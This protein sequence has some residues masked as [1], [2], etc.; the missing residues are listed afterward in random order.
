MGC[1]C[2]CEEFKLVYKLEKSQNQLENLPSFLQ[3]NWRKWRSLRALKNCEDRR[4]AAEGCGAANKVSFWWRYRGGWK[5][6]DLLLES[7]KDIPRTQLRPLHQQL[8]LEADWWCCCTWSTADVS[9]LWT[10]KM[11]YSLSLGVNAFLWQFRSGGNPKITFQELMGFGFFKGAFPAS[12]TLPP[13][14]LTSWQSTWKILVSRAL[15]CCQA[16]FDTKPRAWWCVP[17]WMISSVV[18][19][20]RTCLVGWRDREK[21]HYF[22]RGCCSQSTPRSSRTSAFLEEALLL[23]NQW[24]ADRSTWEVCWWVGEA[25]RPWCI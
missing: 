25:L 18:E 19:K 17:M 6:V 24:C 9:L 11:S 1:F 13:I 23:H 16:C 8:E 12:L 5:G 14:S 20:R 15:L 22:K 7:P 10:S 4:R 2:K 21:I 3:S